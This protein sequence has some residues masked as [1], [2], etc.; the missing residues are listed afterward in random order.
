MGAAGTVLGRAGD[1]VEID[2]AAVG[3]AF[4]DAV[5]DAVDQRVAVERPDAVDVRGDPQ[6]ILGA[7]LAQIA[8]AFALAACVSVAFSLLVARLLTP[9]MAANLLKPA[10]ARGELRTIAATTWG[11]YKKYFE[12]DAALARRFQVVKVEEP[13]EPVAA[14]GMDTSRIR[15]RTRDLKIHTSST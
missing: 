8:A 11:E 12:K 14:K 9:M 13:S 4:A 3:R 2:G 7:D 15:G 6:E 5:G 1:G 10:L